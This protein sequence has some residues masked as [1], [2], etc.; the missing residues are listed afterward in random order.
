LRHNLR[1]NTEV[2][3]HGRARFNGLGLSIWHDLESRTSGDN[4]MPIYDEEQVVTWNVLGRGMLRHIRSASGAVDFLDVGTGSGFWAIKVA[5]SLRTSR[6]V[7]IAID[8]V[9]RAIDTARTNATENG[10]KIDLRH[11]SYNSDSVHWQTVRAIFMNAP[12]HI[13]PP[14]CGDSVPAYA[15]GG[16][17][18]FEEFRTWLSIADDHISRDG[19][20]FFHQMCLGSAAG[21]EFMSFAPAL[22]T[23]DPSIRYHD[24]LPPIKTSLF[25]KAVYGSRYR[26][27]VRETSELFPMLHYTAGA[28]VRDG[29]GRREHLVAKADLMAGKTWRDRVAFHRRMAD[30]QRGKRR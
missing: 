27:F 12:Y 26:S 25:L 8:E 2:H 16:P 28:V 20:I 1:L 3:G 11:E 15:R 19:A 24:L 6:P 5:K 18:G 21:P 7:V 17:L 4:V 14:E 23:G 30:R 29:R 10:V 13:Y 22:I 9:Q